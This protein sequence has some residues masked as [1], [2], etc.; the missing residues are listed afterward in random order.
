MDSVFGGCAGA[1][2]F[3]RSRGEG[4]GGWR[5]VGCRGGCC[6]RLNRW[7]RFRRSCAI[8]SSRLLRGEGVVGG[9]IVVGE[10]VGVVVGGGNVV[11]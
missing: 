2:H 7:R 8:C 11:V 4:R 1:V 6:L 5:G 9:G 10:G 3:V